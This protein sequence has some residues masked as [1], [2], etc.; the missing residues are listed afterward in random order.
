MAIKLNDVT[1]QYLT[2]VNF[3]GT[4]KN[5]EPQL[6][7]FTLTESI[8]DTT[9]YGTITL[10]DSIDLQQDLPLIGEETVR[11]RYKSRKEDEYV[12]REFY[13]YRMSDSY[14]EEGTNFYI[15]SVVS[16]EYM[17]NLTKKKYR[18]YKQQP[19]SNIVSSIISE[20]SE[21]DIEIEPTSNSTAFITS[22]SSPL[23]SVEELAK[24]A[25]S[26]KYEGNSYLFW[27][28]ADK[29][30]FKTVESLFEQEAIDYSYRPVMNEGSADGAKFFSITDLEPVQQF[31]QVDCIAEGMYG[32]ACLCI[33]PMT[34]SM[35]VKTFDYFDKFDSFKHAEKDEDAIN[36]GSSKFEF[37]GYTSKWA[38]SLSNAGRKKSSYI[39]NSG[40]LEVFTTN[41]D[42]ILNRQ[43]QMY[44][45]FNTL[46]VT[47][48]VPGNSNL[49]AG[50]IINVSI[51][52]RSLYDR[53]DMHQ[54]PRND[55][56]LSGR[57]IATKVTHILGDKGMSTKL[58]LSKDSYNTDHEDEEYL[59]DRQ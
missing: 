17:D 21:K 58:Q 36:M 18:S 19:I 3:N 54:V 23:K 51:P 35:G 47:A 40:K 50:D 30:N 43:S 26:G 6:H 33:D 13:V 1:V 10:K 42:S 22:K 53:D 16:K 52:S 34:R 39:A 2:F 28:D 59:N 41:E 11:I 32:S 7:A 56:F 12:D 49:R 8:F 9:C 14:R 37:K 38:S 45:Y 5:V 4:P 31:N 46:I 29:F 55:R 48:I 44:Q 27:E 24:I 20:I 57:Y 15:L 25:K